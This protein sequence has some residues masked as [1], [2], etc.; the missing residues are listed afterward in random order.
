VIALL[1]FAVLLFG[2]AALPRNTL[3]DP[4]TMALVVSHRLELAMAGTAALGA[5]VV[6]LFLS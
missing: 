5:A 2:L 1:G 3:P 6:A 4:R